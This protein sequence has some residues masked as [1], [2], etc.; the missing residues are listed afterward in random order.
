MKLWMVTPA[1]NEA[2][3]MGV[4]AAELVERPLWARPLAVNAGGT[5]GHSDVEIGCGYRRCAICARKRVECD[6]SSSP[7]ALDE[8]RH[9]HEV[10]PPECLPNR[11]PVHAVS[12]GEVITEAAQRAI[13]KEMT[14]M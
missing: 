7:R 4:L 8:H 9:S 10:D 14:W 3:S 2:D 13:A 1:R 6:S 5:N 12:I 11:E